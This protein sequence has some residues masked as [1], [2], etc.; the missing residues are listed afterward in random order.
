VTNE[1]DEVIGPCQYLTVFF[2]YE[3]HFHDI[4]F[5]V[6]SRLSFHEIFEPGFFRQ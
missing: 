3:D 5:P 6:G 4:S 1:L 2:G